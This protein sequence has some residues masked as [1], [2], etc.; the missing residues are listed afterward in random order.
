MITGQRIHDSTG[1]RL[2]EDVQGNE[3]IVSQSYQPQQ[4]QNICTVSLPFHD[5]D[6]SAAVE[7][8]STAWLPAPRSL[9]TSLLQ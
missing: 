1:Y 8:V 6:E 7:M 3:F 2:P 9:T 5:I 4:H